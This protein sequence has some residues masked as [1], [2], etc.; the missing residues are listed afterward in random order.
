MGEIKYEIDLQPI[1]PTKVKEFSEPI[2]AH[3]LKVSLFVDR[4][5]KVYLVRVSLILFLLTLTA[6]TMFAIPNV[7]FVHDR[8]MIVLSVLVTTV[9][10][11]LVVSDQLPSLGTLTI[12]ERQVVHSYIFIFVLCGEIVLMKIHPNLD[13]YFGIIDGI[14]IVGYLIFQFFYLRRL[15][16]QERTSKYESKKDKKKTDSVS[17]DYKKKLIIHISEEKNS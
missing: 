5:S 13:P 3:S 10:Y 14:S 12:I 1:N 17:A 16:V 8:L 9:A 2:I 4:I 7:D 6:L 15:I 11:T